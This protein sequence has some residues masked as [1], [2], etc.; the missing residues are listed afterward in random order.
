MDYKSE[1]R[2][3]L[4]AGREIAGWLLKQ[5]PEDSRVAVLDSKRALPVFQVDQGA[6]QERLDRMETTPV[7][8]PLWEVLE[9]AAELLEQGEI[10][11][12]PLP[13]RK[14]IYVF[15]DLSQAAWDVEAS[16]ALRQRLAKLDSLGIYVVDVGIKEPTNFAPRRSPFAKRVPRSQSPLDDRH[17]SLQHRTGSEIEGRRGLPLQ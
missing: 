1:N 11:G 10:G 8:Q 17:G 2:T 5:L 14:E 6:A 13:K 15:T 3:R 12:E 7:G 16:K 9:A 4:E